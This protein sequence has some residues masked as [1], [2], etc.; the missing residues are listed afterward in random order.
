MRGGG[1][2]ERAQI[3]LQ[4]VPSITQISVFVIFSVI[5]NIS[6]CVDDEESVALHC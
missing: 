3:H 1:G 5:R 6:S 2:M 4:T